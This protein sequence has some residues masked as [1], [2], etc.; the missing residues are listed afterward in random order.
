MVQL[1]AD[2][3]HRR[4]VQDLALLGVDDRDEVGCLDARAL[5]EAGEV[6]E[7][8]LRRL[9]GVRRGAVERWSGAVLVHGLLLCQAP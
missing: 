6:E 7:L 8:L 2:V 9:L 5:V 3:R 4:F 1:V